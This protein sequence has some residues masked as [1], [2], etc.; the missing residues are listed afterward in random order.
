MNTRIYIPDWLSWKPYNRQVKTDLYYLNLCNQVRRE[1]VTGDQAITLLSY[2]SY[3][4]LNQLCCF[5]TSYFEDLISGTN[6]WNSFV[7]VH[8]RLYKKALP[9]YDLDEYVEKEINYQDISFLIWYFLNTVQDEKFVSPFHDFIL[10]S[11][12]KVV[13]VFDEAWEYAPENEQLLSCYQLDD[14]EE[15]FYRA[16]NLIDTLIFH[17]YLFLVDFGRALKERE[18]EIIEKQVYNENLLPFLNENRD[19]MLHTSRSRLLSLTGKEWVA[20]ILREEHPL[21]AEF[22]KMSQKINGFF[23]Y[24]GQDR[25]DV[26]LEHIASGKEFKMTKKSFEHSDSLQET[27][28]IVFIGLVRWRDEWWFSGTHYQI[29]FNAD[30][31]LEEKQSLVSRAQVNFLD[32]SLYNADETLRKQE[33]AFLDYNGGSQIA[34]LP[35]EKMND[36]LA[37]FVKH[38]NDSLNLSGEEVEQSKKRFRDDGIP[39]GNGLIDLSDEPDTPETGLVFFNPKRGCEVVYGVNSAFPLPNN[40]Y[41]QEELSQ[42][43]L[44]R[45]L[46]DPSVSTEIVLFCINQ[47]KKKL[48]V[49]K[50]SPLKDYLKDIDFLLRFWK[51]DNYHATP[52]ITFIGEKEEQ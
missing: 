45:L 39:L 35:S 36:F 10:E 43:H 48:T 16:R 46:M 49:L 17:S 23:L 37:G 5:L 24:K 12:E 15:D 1:L 30:L 3:D 50:T 2:L 29:P 8:T 14:D 34:F 11:A 20:E 26:F 21:R 25:T 47:C 40:P 19:V 7:S 33:K 44:M 27:D 4:Q 22:L 9:F 51:K 6:L 42:E 32:H 52:A 13:Q 28:T 18:E 41:F 31:I 38:F